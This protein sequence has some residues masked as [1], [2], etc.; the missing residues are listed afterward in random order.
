MTGGIC[1]SRGLILFVSHRGYRAS[2][3]RICYE[4]KSKKVLLYCRIANFWRLAI[5]ESKCSAI[6]F[7]CCQT[8]CKFLVFACL[9]AGDSI[10]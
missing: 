10:H 2:Y 7:N 4:L 5:N 8:S 1:K 3:F 9:H 6:L